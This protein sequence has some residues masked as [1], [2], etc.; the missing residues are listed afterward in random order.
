[1]GR[2]GSAVFTLALILSLRDIYGNSQKDSDDEAF[3]EEFGDEEV[4]PLDSTDE[5]EIPVR[6]PTSHFTAPHTMKNL[7]VMKFSFWSVIIVSFFFF[8]SF[9]SGTAVAFSTVLA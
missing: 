3:S 6:K 2:L 1:M 9:G 7:P 4:T 8:F 5:G